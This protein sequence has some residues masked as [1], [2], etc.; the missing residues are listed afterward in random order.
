MVTIHIG[1]IVKVDWLEVLVKNLD[2]FFLKKAY[3]TKPIT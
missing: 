2:N 1:E 3:K